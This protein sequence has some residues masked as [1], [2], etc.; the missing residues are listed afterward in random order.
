MSELTAGQIREITEI[1]D[2]VVSRRLRENSTNRVTNSTDG[3]RRSNFS[4]N[5]DLA[6][7]GVLTSLDRMAFGIYDTSDAFSDVKKI[8][9]GIL[10]DFPGRDAFATAVEKI[11]NTGLAMNRSMMDSAKSGFTF[12]QNLGLYDEAVLSARMSLKDWNAMVRESGTQLVGL[13]SD[14]NKSGLTFLSVAKELQ[15]DPK[16]RNA[17]IAGV[18]SFEEYNNALKI[19][20]QTNKFNNLSEAQTRKDMADSARGLVF[21]LDMMAKLTGKS[22]EK[23]AKDIEEQNATAQMRLRIASM[24][25][26][27]RDAYIKNQAVI[28]GLPK[29]AQELL[30]AYSTGGLRNARDRENA[31]AFTGTNIEGIIQRIAAIKEVTPEADEQRRQL[32][33]RMQEELAAIGNDRARLESMSVLAGTDN[34]FA[35]KMG[36]VWADLGDLSAAAVKRQDE[37]FQRGE[38]MSTYITRL[39]DEAMA[40]IKRVGEKPETPEEKAASASR[41]LN[42]LDAKIKDLNAGAAVLFVDKINSA[43]GELVT[44]FQGLQDATRPFTTEMFKNIGPNLEKFFKSLGYTGENITPEDR[45]NPMRR[46]RQQRLNNGQE[47]SETPPRTSTEPINPQPEGRGSKDVWGDWF[48]GKPGFTMIRE[49]GP[50]AVVPQEKIGE[51]IKDMVAKT[52]EL[53]SELQGTLKSSLAEARSAQPTTEALRDIFSNI[54]SVQA[55]PTTEGTSTSPSTVFGSSNQNNDAMTELIKGMNQLNIRVERL[56]TAV[57]DGA[58]KNVRATKTKGNLIA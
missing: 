8:I 34:P 49:Q 53:L 6:V 28:Q 51:F 43:T 55:V 3:T 20:S 48:G 46:R 36:A 47:N 31:A 23:M 58:D 45:D 44:N 39:Y 25:K 1:V 27:E 30:T 41:L 15:E 57:E 52:P 40:K 22:R 4:E 54:G 29:A 10:P 38:T 56:I 50:E 35:Q 32:F 17:I 14:A 11:G 2:Q 7:G 24:T 13:S 16:V 21:E 18:G 9:K 37:A 5:L 42:S 33:A 12:S 26:E 19:V